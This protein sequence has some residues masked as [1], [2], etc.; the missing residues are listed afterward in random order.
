MGID[1]ETLNMGLF[2]S[3]AANAS[4]GGLM[5]AIMQSRLADRQMDQQ[6]Q[7][8]DAAITNDNREYLRKR[9]QDIHDRGMEKNRFEFDKE[10]Y[11]TDLVERKRQADQLYELGLIEKKAYAAYQNARARGENASASKI[12][13]ESARQQIEDKKKD[14]REALKG[15]VAY[16]DRIQNDLGFAAKNKGSE[17]H[18]YHQQLIAAFD[19]SIRQTAGNRPHTTEK[20][21]PVFQYTEEGIVPYVSTE[22][23]GVQPITKGG[24]KYSQGGIPVGTMSFD[25]V[26]SLLLQIAGPS[27]FNTPFTPEEKASAA[28]SKSAEM[29]DLAQA[30]T[31]S[32]I[33]RAGREVNTQNR[34]DSLVDNQWTVLND[35]YGDAAITRWLGLAP[36][37]PTSKEKLLEMYTSQAD[38]MKFNGDLP[39]F[40]D[41]WSDSDITK[42]KLEVSKELQKEVD[43]HNGKYV[44]LLTGKYEDMIPKKKS[45]DNAQ[46]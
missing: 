5:G 45:L 41:Q 29:K 12:E 40:E 42:L 10:K 13:Y 38:K 17:E 30:E 35:R 31:Q 1:L 37:T 2:G 21:I 14:L 24:E 15:S 36:D 20:S 32:T 3:P 46:R 28:S 44:S 27:Y 43:K 11:T 16:L 19:P 9:D 23:D 34:L 6:Q 25:Q 8:L 26:D 39:E 22:K 4:G 18:K 7:F 33:L